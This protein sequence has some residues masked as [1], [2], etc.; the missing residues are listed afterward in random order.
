MPPIVSFSTRTSGDANFRK[1]PDL[2]SARNRRFA[3]EEH[4]VQ[5][6]AGVAVEADR[7]HLPGFRIVAETRRIGHPD[8]LEFRDGTV[9][10]SGAGMTAASASG[11]VR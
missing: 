5:V 1:A 2:S 6:A 9:I 8:E 4:C 7:D 3:I 11:S 10:S